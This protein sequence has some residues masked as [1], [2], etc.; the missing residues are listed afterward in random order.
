MS[1]ISRPPSHVLGM[2]T[3]SV[4]HA[5]Q[6]GTRPVPSG[7]RHSA[8][9]L[10]LWLALALVGAKAVLIGRPA[11]F[12]MGGLGAFQRA[13]AIAAHEDVLFA[14]AFGAVGE[15]LLRLTF[16]LR[17]IHQTLWVALI[18]L[19]TICA[20]FGIFNVFIFGY[21]GAPLTA[22]LLAIAG[23]PRHVASSVAHFVT[24]GNVILILTA[25]VT[26]IVLVAS[27][28]RL[29]RPRTR[30]TAA[31]HR[32][33]QA[34]I[35]LLAVTYVVFA[36]RAA[37]G[38]DW[39]ER[40]NRQ[41]STNAHWALL[42][43]F[44][45]DLMAGDDARLGGSY[46]AEYLTDFHLAR[47]RPDGSQFNSTLPALLPAGVARPRNVITIVLESC[48]T[49]HLSLYGCKYNATPR[50]AA[51]AAAGDLLV[52]DNFY[53]H[54]GLTANSLVAIALSIF[55]PTSAWPVT[56]RHPAIPGVTLPQALS[57]RGYRSAFISSGDND[58][59][60]QDQFLANRGFND[61]W[62]ARALEQKLGCK[63]LFSWGV[64]D[65]FMVDAMLKWIDQDPSHAKPFYL[66]GWT[67]QTHHP[68]EM[69][70]G[71]PEI[72]FFGSDRLPDAY[73]YNH[74]LNCLHTADQQVGRLL[75]E[76]H[77]RHLDDDTIVII[78]GDHG[79]AFGAP[80]DV[81][82]HGSNVY[83]ENVHVPL[84]IWSPRLFKHLPAAQRRLPQV[85]GHVDLNPTIFDLLDL[86]Q[87]P[88]SW[89]GHSLFDS[90]R[91]PRAYFFSANGDHLL[92]VRE[93]SW[94]YVFNATLARATLYNLAA[95]PNEQRDVAPGHPDLCATFHQRLS[96]W[97]AHESEHYQDLLSGR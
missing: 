50:L 38:P 92:A 11:S 27:S 54:Q 55:P 25:L 66:L 31:M 48:P 90:A 97:L 13:L 28:H 3:A 8:G 34:M 57:S 30:A 59:L 26:F 61:V 73:D 79:E 49:Q 2:A 12:T 18:L 39:V 45:V 9:W 86:P 10:T 21:V 72:P 70:E 46:P 91:P 76:L 44:F 65:R 35:A 20:F 95:D 74:Y 47:Q 6:T 33:L 84:M 78:T 69:S 93:G 82:G 87:A 58:Y 43:S 52:F 7:R 36:H 80:H 77:Q 41:I 15:L 53:C 75:D 71:A 56:A 19:A 63:R 29:F 32:G 64:D 83:E 24:L 14:L 40:P 62:D 94:K 89:Q 88:E 67:Q 23:G 1:I 4:S 81:W 96:A 68:Y 37:G 5:S 16:R 60:T 42:R 85:G 17:P 51:E 22:P